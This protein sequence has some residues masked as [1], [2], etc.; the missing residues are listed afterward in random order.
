MAPRAAR[1]ADPRRPRPGRTPASRPLRRAA[2]P[3]AGR[4]DG[5]DRVG[6][7]VP[8]QRRTHAEG[9]GI[10]RTAAGLGRTPGA[11]PEADHPHAHRRRGRRRW[12]RR[13]RGVRPRRAGE[14]PAGRRRRRP[15]DQ[16][17]GAGRAG[18]APRPTGTGQGPMGRAGRPA[19]QG[20]AEGDRAT[21]R[22]REDRRRGDPRGRGGRRR[23][24]AAGRG[25]RRRPSGRPPLRRGRPPSHP[26]RHPAGR[27]AVTLRPYQERGLSWL[28][29]CPGVGLGGVL[30]DDMGL[31]KTMQTL[32]LL[33]AP[34]AR[35]GD[36]P[37][38]DAAGLP[39]VASSATGRRRPPGSPRPPASS[40]T[41]AHARTRGDELHRSRRRGTP[42]SSP[43]TAP[44]PADLD[45]LAGRP[46]GPA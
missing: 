7:L 8:P 32:A 26:G 20:G 16:R 12:G 46:P 42:W 21:R 29:S 25:R 24:A 34:S 35:A 2:R 14:R 38:A 30:A 33:A 27:C 5:R 19:G 1:G 23:E 40:S 22:R 45:L 28:A 39:D 31:G 43:A 11:G 37:R 15:H 10:R 44:A 17:G 13:G 3:R 41:T 4:P 18:R 9:G 6:V 36:R